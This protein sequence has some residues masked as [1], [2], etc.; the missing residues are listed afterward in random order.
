MRPSVEVLNAAP[1][2]GAKTRAGNPCRQAAV[3]GKRR[4]RMHGGTNPGAPLGN[5]NNWKH[6]RYSADAIA[7]RAMIRALVREGRELAG[8][9]Q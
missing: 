5:R 8:M 1:R 7:T 9:V 4:C 3:K 2:C 6:G